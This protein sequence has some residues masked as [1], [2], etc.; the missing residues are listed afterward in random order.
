MT[1]LVYNEDLSELLDVVELTNEEKNIFE[2]ENNNKVLIRANEGDMSSTFED[3][4]EF[5]DF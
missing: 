5:E 4:E 3:F 1:Y 2:K